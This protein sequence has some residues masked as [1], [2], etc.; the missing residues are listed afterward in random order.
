MR[1]K[2]L[3][4]IGGIVFLNDSAFVYKKIACS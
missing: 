4:T 2:Q 1:L 3:R